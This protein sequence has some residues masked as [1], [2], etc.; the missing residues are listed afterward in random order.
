MKMK[1]L[2]ILVFI[3]FVFCGMMILSF[4]IPRE[5]IKI[6]EEWV[7]HF[8]SIDEILE[9]NQNN[10]V[11][12]SEIIANNQVPD[13]I[14]DQSSKLKSKYLKDSSIV[15]YQPLDIKPGEVTRKL[16]F[17]GNNKKVLYPFF[18][19]LSNLP[20]SNKLIRVLHYGDSQ[21]EADRITSYLRH[22]LQSQ[23]G[24]SGPGLIPA[25]QPYGFRSPV[26]S[27]SSGEWKRYTGF[28]KRDTMVEHSRYGVMASFSRFS[29]LPQKLN[30]IDS[31]N[32]DTIPIA[33]KEYS[34]SLTIKHSPYAVNSVKKYSQARL[35][36]GYNTKPFNLKLFTGEDLL[37]DNMLIPSDNMQLKRWNF[38][39]TPAYLYM[40]F[41]GEDSPDIYA[42][43]LDA[44]RGIAVD[45]IALRGS[46]GL[47][48]TNSSN[49]LLASIYQKLN[50]KLI[51]LQFGGNI[52]PHILESYNYYERSFYRQLTTLKRLIPG[53]S[54]IVV[55]LA[56]MS[57]KDKDTYV[58]YPNVTLI[59]D[60]LKNASFKADC[61]FWDMYEAMGGE[62]SMPSWVFSEP[63]LAEKD[64]VHFNPRGARIIA[65]MLYR[66]LML[67]YNAYI[68]KQ[69]KNKE[70]EEKV[71]YGYN[72]N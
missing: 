16:E 10:Y 34:A 43:A 37:T 24:G 29:P 23:F 52:T 57:L 12:I 54:I 66:A 69:D 11:D 47:I 14:D 50:V 4:V 8:P 70:V 19:E 58:S 67:E 36:Y 32:S 18:D 65:Q 44:Y 72:E 46:G 3:L 64:F 5:G 2:N 20:V 45:N 13:T 41:K 35:F 38:N 15:Y 59:R 55:G 60:A 30:S 53:V 63:P 17:P 62:N 25:I 26:V 27:E 71:Q 21:I 1:P 28:A 61:A 31:L 56:D 39:N 6:T 7:L 68:R 51:I 42:M 40:E 9:S 33:K 48:F 49:Q 22:K